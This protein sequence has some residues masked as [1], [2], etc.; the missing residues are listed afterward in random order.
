MNPHKSKRFECLGVLPAGKPALRSP[1]NRSLP[2]ARRGLMWRTVLLGVLLIRP[3]MAAPLCLSGP[4][5]V[6]A[7]RTGM[8][9]LW[10]T[11]SESDVLG[12][13]C[14]GSAG[15]AWPPG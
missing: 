2:Q 12:S 9:V 7:E 11:G 8:T 3:S 15:R 14:T 13:T 5:M 1:P 10:Q 6:V 4:P